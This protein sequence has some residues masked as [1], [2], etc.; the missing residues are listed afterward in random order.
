MDSWDEE[1]YARS[2]EEEKN[3]VS[4][5]MILEAVKISLIPFTN[6]FLQ[7]AGGGWYDGGGHE[8]GKEM[9]DGH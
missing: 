4:Q 5:R 1:M 9:S 7:S 2:E 6:T 8:H 3:D